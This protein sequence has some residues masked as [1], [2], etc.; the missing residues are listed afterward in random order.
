M[1]ANSVVEKL[2][3]PLVE[4]RSSTSTSAG[5]LTRVGTSG[6]E[7]VD[8]PL[9][10]DEGE[11]SFLPAKIGPDGRP[12]PNLAV[13]SVVAPYL[14]D[15]CFCSRQPAG[16]FHCVAL[17]RRRREGDSPDPH[18]RA[19]QRE[20]ISRS[21]GDPHSPGVGRGEPMSLRIVEGWIELD[22]E[23][24]ARLL[25]KLRLTLLDGLTEAFDSIDEDAAYIAELEERLETQA[26]G[27]GK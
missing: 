6:V 1:G 13:R 21:V 3:L 27:D 23:R 5:E 24:V 16:T 22:G 18:T 10:T 20:A 17:Q 2:R 26:A 19:D 9:A 15:L 4:A 12:Q 11:T 8:G 25:P 14:G 7:N